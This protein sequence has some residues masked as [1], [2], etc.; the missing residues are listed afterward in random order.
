MMVDFPI[1]ENLT[2]RYQSL[3]LRLWWDR[4][5]DEEV[6]RIIIQDTST[7]EWHGVQS[8]GDLLNLLLRLIY[9]RQT[10]RK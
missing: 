8:L 9:E 3:M 6:L 10:K 7:G 4:T 1:E 5:D 2:S